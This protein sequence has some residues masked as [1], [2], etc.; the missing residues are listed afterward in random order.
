ME[1]SCVR[2]PKPNNV[3]DLMF[4]FMTSEAQK[5][6]SVHQYINDVKALKVK[7]NYEAATTVFFFRGPIITSFGLFKGQFS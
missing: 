6:R 2:K 1:R 7:Q 3:F 4:V 5:R